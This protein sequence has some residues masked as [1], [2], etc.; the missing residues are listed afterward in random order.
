MAWVTVVLSLSGGDSLQRN[1]GV[2]SRFGS[3]VIHQ[4]PVLQSV[5]WSFFRAHRFGFASEVEL[6][7]LFEETTGRELT[8][9]FDLIDAPRT[10]D[11]S[12]GA[13]RSEPV[14]TPG[15]AVD[16]DA[17]GPQPVVRRPP[18][19]QLSVQ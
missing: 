10:L 2:E 15:G 9:F 19:V 5:V 8:W 7:Q 1:V 6:Q 12:V 16:L 4:L 11:F 3:F 17:G 14:E 18:R 13:V